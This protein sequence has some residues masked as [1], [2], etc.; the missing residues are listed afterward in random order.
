MPKKGANDEPLLNEFLAWVCRDADARQA[1][2]G[3]GLKRLRRAAEIAGWLPKGGRRGRG[4]SLD[5]AAAAESL[6][7]NE[8]GQP[9]PVEPSAEWIRLVARRCKPVV[10]AEYVR[11]KLCDY[12]KQLE[13]AGDG[14]SVEDDAVLRALKQLPTQAKLKRAERARLARERDA[15]VRRRQKTAGPPAS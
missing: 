3:G 7:W 12:R 2:Q 13:A 1:A 9:R 5:V 15:R 10:Q 11:K 6:V 8:P 14:R 4:R